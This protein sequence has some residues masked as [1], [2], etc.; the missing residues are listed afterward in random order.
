LA[1]K[2]FTPEQVAKLFEAAEGDWK[3]VR[4]MIHVFIRR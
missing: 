3:G 1:Q 4:E 2:P